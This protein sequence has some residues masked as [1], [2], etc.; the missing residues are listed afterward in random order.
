MNEPTQSPASAHPQIQAQS[1][2]MEDV[3][4]PHDRGIVS[5]LISDAQARDRLH[6]DEPEPD[7]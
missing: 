5:D 6:L 1:E 2:M 7:E 3:S 4:A